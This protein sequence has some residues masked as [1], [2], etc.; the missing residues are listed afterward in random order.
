MLKRD[1]L[2][3]E[4]GRNLETERLQGK[5]ALWAWFY[6]GGILM[7][8]GGKFKALKIHWSFS[9]SHFSF[10]IEAV[11]WWKSHNSYSP[12]KWKIRDGK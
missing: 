4:K 10:S 1:N 12:T 8:M 3:L 11:K 9:I 7:E 6:I 5:G 2:E